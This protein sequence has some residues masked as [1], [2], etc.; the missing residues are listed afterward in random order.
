MDTF[1]IVFAG[2]LV[3]AGVVGCIFPKLP[4]T[5]LC[6]FGIIILHYSSAAQFSTPFF[7]RWGLIVISVQGL[8][9]LIPTWGKR[10]FGGSKLGVWG[11][12]MGML[13]G[14]YFETWGIILGAILGAFVGELVAGKESNKA[15]H[16]AFSSFVFFILGTISQLMVAGILLYYYIDEIKYLL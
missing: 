6:Y 13:A 14:M 1:L 4:G 5:P 2:F 9:Y 15:I 16:Q 10:K 8:D 7:I 3:I 12:L 11:S